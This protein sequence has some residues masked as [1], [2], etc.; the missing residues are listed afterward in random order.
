MNPRPCACEVINCKVA[1]REVH[2]AYQSV[3]Q[4][5]NCNGKNL[6]ASH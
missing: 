5:S 4:K 3:A 6:T 1:E 2:M